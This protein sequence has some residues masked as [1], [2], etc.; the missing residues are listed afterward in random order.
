MHK[1]LFSLERHKLARGERIY[2]EILRLSRND[3]SLLLNTAVQYMYSA[4][5]KTIQC[6]V[7]ILFQLLQFIPLCLIA[8]SRKRTNSSK[9]MEQLASEKITGSYKKALKTS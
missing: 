8:I 4:R 9:I 6:L 5:R 3:V 1:Q 7:S 2:Y